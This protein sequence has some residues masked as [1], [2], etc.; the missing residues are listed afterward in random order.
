MNL[1]RFIEISYT[2]LF[3]NSR[4]QKV[5]FILSELFLLRFL[6]TLQ[7]RIDFVFGKCG[8]IVHFQLQILKWVSQGQRLWWHHWGD[9]SQTCS[10]AASPPS[11]IALWFI[12]WF[13]NVLERAPSNE[14][15]DW[16]YFV[17]SERQHF[18]TAITFLFLLEKR[19]FSP[20]G[21]QT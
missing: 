12:S 5:S 1:F 2:F 17:L 11:A 9:G 18:V 10:S 20:L 6:Q 16:V 19:P 8:Y 15:L 4:I 14:F 21:H 7:K 3:S 13:L